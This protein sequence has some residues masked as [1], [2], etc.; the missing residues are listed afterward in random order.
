[1][2]RH[3]LLT[4]IAFALAI[5]CWGVSPAWAQRETGPFAG[6]FGGNRGADR[7]QTLDLR[8]AFFGAYDDNVLNVGDNPSPTSVDPRFQQSGLAGGA[9]ASLAYNGQTDH[10]RLQVSG[11]GSLREYAAGHNISAATYGANTGLAANFG[12]KFAIEARGGYFYA[13]FYQIGRAHV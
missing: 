6:L 7:A 4:R 3:S 1:M 10:V 8:G 11:E 13:P 5:A 12:P 2:F 9:S